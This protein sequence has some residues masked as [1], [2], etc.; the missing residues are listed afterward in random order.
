MSDKDCI[1][2]KIIAGEIPS[3]IL[4]QDKDVIAFPDIHPLTPV[5]LLIIPRKHIPS[6]SQMTDA[7]TPLI[8]K[9]VKAANQLAREQDMAESGYRLTINSGAS[10][11]QVVPH[12][13]MHLM[14]G[15]ALKWS[16]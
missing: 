2:C 15:R 9:M 4:Y 11:G 3:K 16:H 1:F 5:H 12:L 7:E 14:G 8:G 13:H 6:L 10:A